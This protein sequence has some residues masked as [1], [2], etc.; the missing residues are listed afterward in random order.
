[1]EKIDRYEK[2]QETMRRRTRPG[3]T[4]PQLPLYHVGGVDMLYYFCRF[5]PAEVRRFL[6][7]ELTG[8]ESGWGII[9]AYTAREAWGIGPHSCFYFGFEVEGHDSPDGGSAI[10]MAKTYYSANALQAFRAGQNRNYLEGEARWESSQWPMSMVGEVGGRQA[11]RISAEAPASPLLHKE[12]INRYIGQHPQG[13][14]SS[15]FISFSSPYCEVQN[16]AIEFLDGAGGL[17]APPDPLGFVWP[18]HIANMSMTYSPVRRLGVDDDSAV[19]EAAAAALL[20][21]FARLGRAAAILSPSNAVM[22]LND[23]AHALAQRGGISLGQNGELGGAAQDIAR[24]QAATAEARGGRRLSEAV[25]IGAADGSD[26]IL[27]QAM[28]IDPAIAGP[29]HVLVFFDDPAKPLH[30]DVVPLLRLYGLTLAEAKVAGLVG[31]GRSPRDVAGEL[32]LTLNTVR[33]ALKIAFD[34]LGISR[35]SELAMIVA[36]LAG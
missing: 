11:L 2:F 4:A 32:E 26:P 33:S 29:G 15:F 30:Q 12:G 28:A 6:P 7:D 9:T 34:K 22:R 36:R 16:P 8:T 23:A 24:L 3:Y 25:V 5:D 27:C 31:A 19:A 10:Y 13:G 1:M 21:A 18:I 35:Q 17:Y 20:D 14:L